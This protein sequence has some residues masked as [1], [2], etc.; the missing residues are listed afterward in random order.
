MLGARCLRSTRASRAPLGGGGFGAP[1]K[2]D[3][4]PK[5]VGRRA[6]RDPPQQGWT[7]S[8]ARNS[9]GTAPCRM[10][11]LPSHREGGFFWAPPPAF[12][13]GGAGRIISS[14]SFFIVTCICRC[15]C[16]IIIS[17]FSFHARAGGEAPPA[18]MVAPCFRLCWKKARRAWPPGLNVAAP[19]SC[20]SL[21]SR[22]KCRHSPKPA[23]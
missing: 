5:G 16:T 22:R 2:E 10:H 17:R 18:E 20:R 3:G 8:R 1:P 9:G 13:A 19:L 23:R 15:T 6:R 12:G 7:R 14:S 11:K 21:R 4:S